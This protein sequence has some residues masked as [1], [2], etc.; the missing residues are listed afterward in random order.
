MPK[1]TRVFILHGIAA[2]IHLDNGT[3][4]PLVWEEL[5]KAVQEAEEGTGNVEVTN[6]GATIA[7]PA[8]GVTWELADILKECEPYGGADAAGE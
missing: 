4:I 2:G 7:W 3:A 1:V 8:L 5:P 6:D